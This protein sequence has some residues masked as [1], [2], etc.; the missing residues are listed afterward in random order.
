MKC[1]VIIPAG[2]SGK[3]F[4]S[5]LPKQ[6]TELDGIPVI[7]RTIQVFEQVEEIDA[8]I[9][10][11]HTEW[12]TKTKKLV[13]E[14]GFKKVKEV[15][16]GGLERQD[17]VFNGL[18]SKTAKDSE[19]V[20]VHDAVRPFVSTELIKRVIETAEDNGAVIPAVKPSETIK[21]ITAKNIV[22]KT[23]DRSRLSLIQTPQGFWYDIIA[24]A[25][26]KAKNASFNGTD[27][28]SLVEFIG[29]KITAVPG[30]ETNIKITTPFDMKIGKM[31]LEDRAANA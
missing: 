12:F 7:I 18:N 27:S 30:E 23:I 26:E 19:I 4:G 10:V 28:A 31:I 3:R 16:I 15:V 9:V 8:I 14:Y 1:S 21:E 11:V 24:N 5:E 25:Y 22:V 29:F 20:L 13:E 17:S 6:F 2:G